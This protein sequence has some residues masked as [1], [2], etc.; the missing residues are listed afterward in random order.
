MAPVVQ[1]YLGLTLLAQAGLAVGLTIQ[2]EHRF[3][4]HAP[5]VVAIVLASVALYEMFGPI[6]TRW[7]LMRSG[8]ARG[9]LPEELV[10]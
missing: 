4:D 5:A 10:I 2:A 9:E 6:S 3:P 7:A 1:R 8:E